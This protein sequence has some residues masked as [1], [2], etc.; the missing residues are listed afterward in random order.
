M[1]NDKEHYIPTPEFV[2]RFPQKIKDLSKRYNLPK[3]PKISY[4]TFRYYV[5]NKLMPKS[6]ILDK[7][8]H[9]DNSL[10]MYKRLFIIWYLTHFRMTPFKDVKAIVNAPNTK[11]E[12]EAILQ[13][14]SEK[15][16][17]N[18]IFRLGNIRQILLNIGDNDSPVWIRREDMLYTMTNL[19][20]KDIDDF[21]E[22]MLKFNEYS[23]IN[24]LD[25]QEL[26]DRVK[27]YKRLR[28]EISIALNKL[29]KLRNRHPEL[30]SKL[31]KLGN[32]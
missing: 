15:D 18:E 21:R 31:A 27:L 17:L 16:F 2:R 8:A 6:I 9:Y 30:K 20:N 32:I 7:K 23:T 29:K 1:K 4:R 3:P 5:T 24:K 26:I 25:K 14:L 11:R 12:F 10:D 19:I 22:W 13:T 28:K